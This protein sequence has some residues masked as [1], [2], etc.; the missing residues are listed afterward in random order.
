MWFDCVLLLAP[1]IMNK[2]IDVVVAN[3]RK[4]KFACLR[5]KQRGTKGRSAHHCHDFHVKTKTTNWMNR[6]KFTIYILCIPKLCHHNPCS[7][8][9]SYWMC[10]WWMSEKKA[11]KNNVQHKHILV[12][13]L[14]LIFAERDVLFCRGLGRWTWI[15]ILCVGR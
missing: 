9:S 3:Y 10:Q 14:S 12:T 7:S 15:C 11:S 2:R 1:N 6:I 8:G 4:L 5:N 13:R